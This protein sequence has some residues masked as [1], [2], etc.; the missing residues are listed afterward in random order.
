MVGDEPDLTV[1]RIL[2]V[3]PQGGRPEMVGAERDGVFERIN[4][5]TGARDLS[6]DWYP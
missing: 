5:R 4:R 2:L 3:G 6:S 1:T